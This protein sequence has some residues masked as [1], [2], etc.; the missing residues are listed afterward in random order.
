MPL[1]WISRDGWLIM[2]ARTLRTLAQASIAVFFAF[3]LDLLGFSL[4]EIGLLITVGSVGSA[5]LSSSVI[6]IGET[7]GRRRLLI[8]FSLITG[9]AGIGYALTDRYLLLAGITFFV[10]SMAISGSGPRGPFN[11]LETAALPDTASA[12]RRT[13]LYAVA[14][15]GQ[16][17]ARFVG[18]LSASLPLGFVVWFGMSELDS[19]KVMFVLYTVIMLLS[20]AVYLGL[21]P[22]MDSRS[23]H[24]RFQN[25]FTLPSRRTIFSLAAIFSV[26]S[27][28]T[29]FV[30]FSL[31][32]LWFKTKF[33]LDLAQVSFMFAGSMVMNGISLWFAAKLSN[34]IGMLNTI[35]F[36][37]IPAVIFTIAIPF[38]PWAWLA[39]TFWFSRAFFSQMDNAPRQSYTMSIVNRDE[40]VAMAGISNVSQATLGA[41]VPSLAMWLWQAVS[42]SAPFIAA[43]LFK[44]VYLT[45]LYFAFR[46]VHPPQELGSAAAEE[47]ERPAPV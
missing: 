35:V 14:G 45:A 33:G 22:A 26:D 5:V 18:T 34:R 4:T 6:F 8:I 27:F 7:L 41:G 30:F 19:Y 11:P 23:T 9:V 43:G 39:I 29:R 25:P 40:R 16:R 21:S 28:A 12:E 38:A 46:N 36:T 37:H 1:R 31:V 17:I 32:A 15:I 10:G 44:T 2:T 3:Y 47:Q 13:D 20:A 42:A 24:G